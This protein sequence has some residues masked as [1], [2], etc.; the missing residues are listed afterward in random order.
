MFRA[1]MLS[2]LLVGGAAVPTASLAQDGASTFE[3]EELDISNLSGDRVDRSTPRSTVEG[4]VDSASRHDY[5]RAA[6]YLDLSDLPDDR[7][8]LWG[9]QR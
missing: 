9:A 4:F 7:R 5:E 8:L 6:A 3:V 1:G 2:L